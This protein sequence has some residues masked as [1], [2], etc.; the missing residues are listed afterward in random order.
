MNRNILDNLFTNILLILSIYLSI[1][2]FRPEPYFKDHNYF[3]VLLLQVLFS[4]YNGYLADRNHISRTEL[5][6]NG[7]FI[8][9]NKI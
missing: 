8:N 2:L 4:F 3:W 7:K 9:Q 1:Y 6:F 5:K